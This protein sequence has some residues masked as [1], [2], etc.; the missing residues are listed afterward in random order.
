MP[1]PAVSFVPPPN[2]HHIEALATLGVARRYRRGALLIQEGETGDT[3]A[4]CAV[5]AVMSGGSGAF[6][7]T[8]G[9][10]SSTNAT[11]NEILIRFRLNAGQSITAL[12][13]TN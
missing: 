1:A 5:G 6:Q 11:S 12:S 13:F 7:I 8:F 10:E 4:G 2:T 3:L 9:T